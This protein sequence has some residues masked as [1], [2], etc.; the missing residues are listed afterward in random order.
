MCKKYQLNSNK[1][2]LHTVNILY[3]VHFVNNRKKN[4]SNSITKNNCKHEIDFI[5]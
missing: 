1:Y 5:L 3:F 2:I 4:K